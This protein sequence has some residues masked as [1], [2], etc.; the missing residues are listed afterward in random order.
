MTH[1]RVDLRDAFL[2][3]L[4]RDLLQALD[5]EG[6][7]GVACDRCPVLDGLDKDPSIDR[8][9]GSLAENL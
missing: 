6:F 1:Q 9:G 8:N 2:D 5:A 3:I 7:D 4:A